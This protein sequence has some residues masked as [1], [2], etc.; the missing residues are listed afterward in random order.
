MTSTLRFCAPRAALAVI[1]VG[2]AL[3]A[4]LPPV[5]QA[6]SRPGLIASE[7]LGAGIVV[8]PA[9]GGSAGGW[10]HPV[11]TGQFPAWSPNGETLA[12]VGGGVGQIMLAD[13][14]G[15]HFSTLVTDPTGAFSLAWSPDGT[16]IAYMCDG[17][18]VTDVGPYV[19]QICELDVLTGS[20]RFLTNPK[21]NDPA[22]AVVG[23]A[24]SLSWSPKG[25][26]IAFDSQTATPCTTAGVT[27]CLKSEVALL[28]VKTGTIEQ[29]TNHDA[30]AA[31]FSPDGNEMSYYERSG[32]NAGLDVASA[33]GTFLRRV[34]SSANVNCESC[35]YVTS[36]WS[37]DG[38]Q[39]V[40]S[41][42]DRT[43]HLNLFEVSSHGGPTKQ[44]TNYASDIVQPTWTALVTTCTVPKLK[45][46]T[47]AKAKKLI[48]LAGCTLGKITGHKKNRGA[49]K[50]VNQN[51]RARKDVPTGTKINVQI[52]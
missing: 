15:H 10:F 9:G 24:G 31:A 41:A 35:G 29:I 18:S 39:L 14:A 11:S 52:R 36:A 13:R 25:D 30:G 42:A 50:V 7:N 48:M 33:S 45:G 22:H 19:T 27:G 23:V 16:K 3:A 44:L 1:L 12:F 26:E 37:P 8:L 40:F 20:R 51:P 28:N 43:R 6:A 47:F 5:A 21:I 46:Q 34:E 17:T 32:P 4:P 49:L 2:A 38:K